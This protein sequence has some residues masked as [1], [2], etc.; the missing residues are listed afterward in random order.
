[1][2]GDSRPIPDPTVLTTE[3]LHREIA[4]AKEAI[5]IEMDGLRGVIDARFDKVDLRFGLLDGQRIEQKVD[6]NAAV[7][8]ALVAQKE[9][10]KEQT[11]ASDRAIAKSEAATS[12]QLE[13]LGTTFTTAIAGVT[14]TLA[15]LK[16]RV[17]RIESVKVGGREAYAGL[18][19]V[20]I[21][22]AAVLSALITYGAVHK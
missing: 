7:D 19:A 13:Q 21:L 4:A 14:T 3:Q 15:D 20:A 10:V 11:A 12:K 22:F 6:T 5:S 18:Y 9:A 1:M 16:E 17:S 8:A 2:D